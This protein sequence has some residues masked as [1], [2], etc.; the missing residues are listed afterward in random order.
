MID[1]LKLSLDNQPEKFSFESAV[2]EK[3]C[4]Y[5]NLYG[6]ISN[7]YFRDI[8]VPEDYKQANDDFKTMFSKKSF[9]T[10]FLHATLL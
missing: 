2:M 10:L 4:Q 9:H 8:G 5:G 7:G 1:K 3:Q 6:V